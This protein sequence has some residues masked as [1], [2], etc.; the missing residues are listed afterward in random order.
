MADWIAS[1]GT[2]DDDPVEASTI[3][4]LPLGATEQHGPHLPF[5]TDTLIA[6]GICERL[7]GKLP[8]NADVRFLP[9]EP[10]GYSPEHMD[11]TG[12]KSLD[13]TEAIERW[14]AIGATAFAHGVRRLLLLNAHGGNS[15]LAAIVAQELRVRHS[16]LAVVTKWDRFLKGT[17]VVSE[18]EQALGIHGGEIE[19][20]V[21]LA[22]RPDLVDMSKTSDFSNAQS[23]F[24]DTF[25]HLRAYG[26]HA[27][28]WKIQDLNPTGV[29]GNA[30]AASA[31]KGESLLALA[32]D[33]LVELIN[34]VTRFDLTLLKDG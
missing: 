2:L 32:V 24:A 1:T 12:S 18:N 21:M 11:F 5:E 17:D 20:S 31:Q 8:K 29:T 19:T 23:H 15:P 34:D 13:H 25:D 9:V 26:P 10:V 3:V 28:G 14:T 30:A 27:F 33:G 6:Q 16:M 7:I 4:V 22:L